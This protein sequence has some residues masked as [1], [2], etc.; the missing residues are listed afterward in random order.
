MTQMEK[1]NLHGVKNAKKQK[2]I[3]QAKTF[4]QIPPMSTTSGKLQNLINI[5]KDIVSMRPIWMCAICWIV[6]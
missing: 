5:Y 3:I 2:E 4:E 1:D 6:H